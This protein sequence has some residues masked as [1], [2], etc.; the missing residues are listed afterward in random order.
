MIKL[1]DLISGTR[2]RKR[3]VFFQYDSSEHFTGEYD[4]EGNKIYSKTVVKGVTGSIGGVLAVDFPLNI[5]AKR[6]WRDDSNSYF[7]YANG[8]TDPISM[9][10]G[11]S[12]RFDGYFKENNTNTYRIDFWGKAAGTCVLTIRYVK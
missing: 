12:R 2:L 3:N 4:Y 8:N 11:D 1:F 9:Y 5:N 6:A 7:V 10:N